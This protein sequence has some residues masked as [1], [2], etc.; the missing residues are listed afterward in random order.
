VTK[1]EQ[2]FWKIILIVDDEVDITITFKA[3]IEEQ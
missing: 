2:G 1:E 3:G